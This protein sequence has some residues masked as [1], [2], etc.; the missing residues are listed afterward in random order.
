MKDEM[1]LENLIISFLEHMEVERNNSKLTIRNYHHYLSRFYAWYVNFDVNA[2]ITKLDLR[3]IKRYRIYLSRLVDAQGKG[4]SLVTQGYHVIALRSFLKWM[5]KNDYDVMSPEKIDLPRAESKSLKF[6]NESQVD[7]LMKAPVLSEE[8]GLRDRAILEVLY[9]TGLRVSELVK[10]NRDKID[11]KTREFGIVGKGG[12]ARVVFLSPRA[13]DWLKR[14]FDNR[15]DE[16]KPAFIRYS[17]K[18]ASP[19]SDGE[20]MRLTTRSVQRTVEK[21]RLSAK[22][23][24]NITPHGLRHS[25]ATD[26]ISHGAGLREVQEMLGHKNIST[27][28]IYTHVTNPQLKKVHDKFH[29]GNK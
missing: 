19:K 25:F 13:A 3:M 7:R 14:Y 29:S 18:K 2:D 17:K 9:S 15:E 21:Y 4:L 28:Q 24:M 11:F 12:R 26:L 22:L 20:S 23:P 6:L 27:T 1:K 8:A 10:L 5:I 16:W